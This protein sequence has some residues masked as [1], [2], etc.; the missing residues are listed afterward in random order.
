M[1]SKS[2]PFNAGGRLQIHLLVPENSRKHPKRHNGEGEFV[3]W[4]RYRAIYFH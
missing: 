1:K 2:K 3:V 4:V